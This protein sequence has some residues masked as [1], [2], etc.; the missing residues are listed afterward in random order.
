MTAQL[1]RIP[2]TGDVVEAGGLRFKVDAVERRRIA[3]L[4]I[5]VVPHPAEEHA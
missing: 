4:E 3:T 1:A 2:R 5:S